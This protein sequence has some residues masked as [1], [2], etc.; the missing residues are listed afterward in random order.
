MANE[1]KSLDDILKVLEANK[2]TLKDKDTAKSF[3][4]LADSLYNFSRINWE[5]FGGEDAK[6]G[7]AAFGGLGDAFNEAAKSIT[8]LGKGA[9]NNASALIE[10][11]KGLS[12][13]AEIEWQNVAIGLESI[14]ALSGAF[15]GAKDGIDAFRKAIIGLAESESDFYAFQSLADALKSFSDI[16]WSSVAKGLIVMGSISKLIK[17]A[18]AGFKAAGEAV[19]GLAE[20][21][22]SFDALTALSNAFKTFSEIKWKD[23]VYGIF[24]LRIAAIAFPLMGTALKKLEA[25]I[26]G[27]ES[28]ETI[29][30]FA[31]F[32]NALDTFSKISWGKV[33]FGIVT[34]KIFG[35]AFSTI[36][37]QSKVMMSGAKTFSEVA[38]TL[39]GAI[40]DFFRAIPFGQVAKGLL[41]LAGLAID[42]GLLAGAFIL[43]SK[44]SWKDVMYGIGAIAAFTLVA[45]GLGAASAFIAPGLLVLA[46]LGAALLVFGASLMVVGKGLQFLAD[47]IKSI[48]D[49]IPNLADSF[50]QMAQISG[51]LVK[52]AGALAILSAAIVAF[53]A[54]TATGGLVG[55]VGGAVSGVLNFLSGAKSTNPI[56]Q[57]ARLAS[58]GDALNITA[59]AL[60]RINAAVAGMP[61]SSGIQLATGSAT[62][63]DLASQRA[64]ASTGASG[65]GINATAKSISTTNKVSSVIVNNNWMPDRSTALVLAPAI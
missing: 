62:G 13:F 8:G 26:G 19:K 50:T 29:A 59:T 45:A 16:S 43:F 58:M 6:K 63:A 5:S 61:S 36:A 15:A 3:S 48:G 11:S 44:V 31:E 33:I 35:G 39:G 46:G 12:T 38:A 51:G 42:L 7:L 30:S 37:A 55:A 64:M 14:E 40:G 18:G 54:A 53:S 49:T 60:E 56:D 23:V 34:M 27:R 10:L 9:K 1:A 57:I 21:K 25:A 24:G 52:T 28:K 22:D 32:A 47:G 4:S 2:A 20:H 65:G 17:F 41:L